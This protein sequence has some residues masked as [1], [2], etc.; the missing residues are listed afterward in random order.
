MTITVAAALLVGLAAAESARPLTQAGSAAKQPAPPVPPAVADPAAI[1]VFNDRVKAY[2]EL[3]KKIEDDLP[4]LDE[5]KDAKKIVAHKEALAANL[6]VAR[7][8][9]MQGDIFV[10]AAA[11]QF[12]RLI[13]AD[14]NQRSEATADAVL[15]EVPEK[16]RLRVNDAYPEGAPLATMPPKILLRL[17][18]L[19][20]EVEYRFLG[21]HLILRDVGANL[22]VD[23]V[24]NVV[25]AD[26]T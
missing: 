17:P 22:I 25:P 8:G 5:T 15:E 12:R 18:V 23:F 4:S 16:Q 21:R 24:Y 1:Q 3:R 2:V 14:L 10:P 19:P 11:R 7:K 13:S 26:K 9:A 6:R 20:E